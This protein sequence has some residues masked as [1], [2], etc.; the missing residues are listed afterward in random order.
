MGQSEHLRFKIADHISKT[1]DFSEWIA[2]RDV[3]DCIFASLDW[4][5]PS[6][7]GFANASNRVVPRYF[8]RGWDGKAVASNVLSNYSF[9]EF[10]WEEETAYF[11]PPFDDRILEQTVEF[12]LARRIKAYLLVPVWSRSL[13][14]RRLQDMAETFVR[15]P[16][17]TRMFSADLNYSLPKRLPKADTVLVKLDGRGRNILQKQKFYEF[18]WDEFKV[19]K[20]IN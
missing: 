3:L 6:I 16:R 14:C 18:D 12:V 8:N 15:I 10:K 20:V 11:N 5:L 4:E 1:A 13:F 2:N 7:D 19:R 9:L 17:D